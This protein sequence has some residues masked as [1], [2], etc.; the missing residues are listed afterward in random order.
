MW[1]L[2]P[3]STA[4]RQRL[5]KRA[6]YFFTTS[7]RSRREVSAF[8]AALLKVGRVVVI[9]GLLRDLFL[10]G[11]QEFKSDVDFVID[12]DSI[13]EFD[14]LANRLGARVNRFGGY[15]IE[16]RRWKVDVWPRERTWAAVHGYASVS[17]L[18]DLV[19]ATFFDWDAVLYDLASRRVI[20]QRCYFER[21]HRRVID[22]N[23]EPNPN[24]LGNAVRALR[25]AYRW[26]AA[27]GQKL[28]EH[29]AKQI[30]DHGWDKLV[31]TENRSFSTPVLKSF[32]GDWL[33]ALLRE[34][35]RNGNGPIHLPLR[36]VQKEL[37][38]EA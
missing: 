20:T 1:A 7:V 16:L 32:D 37:P 26:D 9:G 25:Y 12:P 29:V 24:P 13:A 2:L 34:N 10:G 5:E 8:A 35:A 21:I 31:A 4:E 30:Q 27:L 22:I 3:N 14:R 19:N 33:T 6:A 11:N 15:C 36:P 23:L 18:P 28:V 17:S 38:F